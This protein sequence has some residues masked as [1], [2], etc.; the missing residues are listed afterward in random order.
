M[1]L[2]STQQTN[3]LTKMNDEGNGIDVSGC[4]VEKLTK[5]G[6]SCSDFTVDDVNMK[7]GDK[8]RKLS[9]N[10]QF[11]DTADKRGHLCEFCV[12]SWKDIKEVRSKNDKYAKAES[13][14]CRFAVLVSLT[15]TRI[16]DQAWLRKLYNSISNQK[17]PVNFA[18]TEEKR[19]EQ[20][21]HSELTEKH[22]FRPGNPTFRILCIIRRWITSRLMCNL[23]LKQFHQS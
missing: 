14:I 22:K 15:S 21:E 17:Q 20:D 16:I 8:L 11:Q 19:Q 1:Y 10:C 9:Y 4:G 18:Y 6:S 3:C 5:T 12:N 23:N 2:N 13:D 7:F